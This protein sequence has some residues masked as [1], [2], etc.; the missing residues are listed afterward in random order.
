MF[1]RTKLMTGVALSVI[2]ALPLAA[3]DAP[4]MDTVVATVNGTDITLGH[5]IV[6]RMGLPE[7]YRNLPDDVLF[8]G[9]LDQLIQQTVLSEEMGDETPSRVALALENERRSMMAAER[10][11]SV[12]GDAITEEAVTKA[13]ADAYAGAEPETEYNA[14][15]ILVETEDEAKALVTELE[16]GADFAELA[17]E[18]STGPSGPRGGELGWFGA[19]MMVPEFEQAVAD[20]DVGAISAPIKTQF[21]WHVI[22]LTES[23]AKDAPDLESVREELE[24]QI[25]Q[26]TVE[27]YIGELTD[28]AD[29][30]RKTETEIDPALLNDMTL[31]EK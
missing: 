1:K 16:G 13:Y 2:L 24:A 4:S 10:I 21:G 11:E 5:M 29:I 25:S 30:S 17:K 15:H 19:G 22:K 23:R 27:K 31:L 28:N 14:S 6:T 3:E 12:L 26:E 18:K 20:M 8:R 9:I 7:Q